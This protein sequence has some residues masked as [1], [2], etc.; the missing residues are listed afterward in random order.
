MTAAPRLPRVQYE[1]RRRKSLS[2]RRTS[3]ATSCRHSALHRAKSPSSC[4]TDWSNAR[5]AI[6]STSESPPS[7]DELAQAYHVA[8]YD[9]SEEASDAAT[10]LYPSACNRR[11]KSSCAAKGALEIGTGTGSL[12]RAPCRRG[13]FAIWLASS[14]RPPPSRLRRRI[15]VDGFAKRSSTNSDF[16]PA[17]FDLICCFMTMEH[18]RDPSAIAQAALRLLRPGGAFVTVTHD[19]RSLVNRLLGRRSPIIDIEH[20]Q[21]FSTA[22]HRV[23]VQRVGIYRR[24][25][26]V[27]SSTRYALR[28]WLRL[29]PV[30][31]ALKRGCVALMAPLRV[32][33]I[34]IGVN[35]GNLITAGFKEASSDFVDGMHFRRTR[36]GMIDATLQTLRGESITALPRRR[37]GQHALRLP[38]LQRR[39]FS[40][41]ASIWLAL[42]L[43]LSAERYSISS[44]RAVMSF[45]ISGLARLPRFLICYAARLYVEP[46]AHRLDYRVGGQCDSG[47]SHPDDSRSRC[48]RTCSCP[49]S[50]SCARSACPRG[51]THVALPVRFAKNASER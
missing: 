30:P 4:A 51:S 20:M 25:R 17:S 11:C 9:S 36:V 2:P 24:H 12:S 3:I 42:L 43:G 44:P 1:F 13:L 47:A 50:Y 46:E 34:K 45:A 21:L 26:C 18:V 10:G 35:V 8:E 29:T 41:G 7:V 31:H 40:F 38:C 27:R 15:G 16:A 33:R 22:K 14:H 32:D 23:P 19:Y 28:Y 5:T 49:G 6:S 39:R 48:W 37:R